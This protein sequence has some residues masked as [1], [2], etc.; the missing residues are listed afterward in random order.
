MTMWLI[1]DADG[2]QSR[3]VDENHRRRMMMQTFVCKDGQLNSIPSAVS[4]NH[5]D[6][7]LE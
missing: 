3:E 1:S 4:A 6:E 5:V 7:E 2:H